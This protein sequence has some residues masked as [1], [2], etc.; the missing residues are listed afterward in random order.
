MSK[1]V[2][3]EEL[4]NFYRKDLEHLPDKRTGSNKSYSMVDAALGAFSVFFMQS[5]SFLAHQREMEAGTKSNNARSLFKIDKIPSDNHIRNLLD[6]VAPNAIFPVF[7]Y[8]FDALEETKHLER[9]RFLDG[10][11]LIPLDGTE[12]LVQTTFIA[13]NV[14]QGSTRMEA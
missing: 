8:V 5:A 12:Y 11:L 6:E 13:I 2:K 3:F 10:Q 9:F 14:L 4:I 1:E 7:D